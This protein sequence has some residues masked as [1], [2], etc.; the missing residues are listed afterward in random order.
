MVLEQVLR[1][2]CLALEE[3]RLQANIH[4]GLLGGEVEELLQAAEQRAYQRPETLL[5]QLLTATAGFPTADTDFP[6]G[7]L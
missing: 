2:E 4:N 5:M 3:L 7:S 6:T 1:T